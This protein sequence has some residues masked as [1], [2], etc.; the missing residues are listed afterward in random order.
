MRWRSG[1]RSLGA[2]TG[3]CLAA[4]LCFTACGPGFAAQP[5]AEATGSAETAPEHGRISCTVV[6]DDGYTGCGSKCTK[7]DGDS[8]NCG[9]CGK[10]C[11]QGQS[12]SGGV[13]VAQ[14]LPGKTAC[15][16]ALTD[17]D[18]EDRHASGWRH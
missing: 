7:L 15:G 9:V 18:R 6:C 11:S 16:G 1:V 17:L 4:N 2:A 3:L 8:A 13:C 12:C 10:A 5:P 14:C